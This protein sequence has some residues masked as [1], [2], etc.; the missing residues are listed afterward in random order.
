MAKVDSRYV[1]QAIDDALEILKTCESCRQLFNS[2]DSNYAIR[3]LARLKHNK[4]F[5]ISEK[6]PLRWVV[7]SDRKL[8][9]I[10][11]SNLKGAAGVVDLAAPR[12]R[13]EMIRPCIYLHPK[14]FIVTGE[15]AEYYALYGLK[16]AVQRAVAILH[17]LG[18]VAGIL[19]YDGDSS[20]EERNKSVANTNCVRVNCI[21]RIVLRPCP[22]A[23]E[24]GRK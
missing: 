13:G 1:D 14:K 10:K 4:V 22:G 12:A 2:E 16:P 3:L 20:K 8:K 17:E 11:T 23:P 6:T 5:V 7:S 19:Q 15:P 24:R 9:T 21:S 18:H